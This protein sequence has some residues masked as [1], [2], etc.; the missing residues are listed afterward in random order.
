MRKVTQL[1]ERHWTWLAQSQAR[2]NAW[3]L[4][5]SELRRSIYRNNRLHF[6]P[7]W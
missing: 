7:G 3:M 2:G 1:S 4:V 5:R 6:K